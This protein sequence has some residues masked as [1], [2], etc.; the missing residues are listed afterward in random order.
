MPNK[1]NELINNYLCNYKSLE[2]SDFVRFFEHFKYSC[3]INRFKN[4]GE[5]AS[6]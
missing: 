5:V 3:T 2:M 4:F 6:T 1:P